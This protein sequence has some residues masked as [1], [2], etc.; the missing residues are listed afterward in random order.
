M[1]QQIEIN[2][3]LL[4]LAKGC[5]TAP[6]LSTVLLDAGCWSCLLVALVVASSASNAAQQSLQYHSP[7]V[8]SVSPSVFLF[9]HSPHKRSV[10]VLDLFEGDGVAEIGTTTAVGEGTGVE[11]KRKR[12]WREFGKGNNSLKW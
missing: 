9:P 1:I 10:G 7:L 5:C 8:S 2:Q 3:Q 6:F 4:T 11:A 12:K